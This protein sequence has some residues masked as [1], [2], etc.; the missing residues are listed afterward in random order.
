RV[1][2]AQ[3]ARSSEPEVALFSVCALYAPSGDNRPRNQF[4]QQTLLL[5]FFQ[6]PHQDFFVLGDFNYHHHLRGT[7]LPEWREWLNNHS[8]DII[9]RGST[10]P[11]PTFHRN[12]S[13]TTIDYIFASPSMAAETG[14]PQNSYIHHNWTDHALLSCAIHLDSLTSG[15]GVWRMNSS[16]LEVIISETRG[17]KSKNRWR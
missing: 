7:T 14:L 8:L 15:P 4:F 17:L 10:L 1:I 3:V 5:P 11:L 9:T 6:Q 13:H 16:L 2:V 12:D